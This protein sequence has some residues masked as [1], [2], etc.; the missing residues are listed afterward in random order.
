MWP[1]IGGHG[2]LFK[3]V[4]AASQTCGDTMKA[5]LILL[6]LP[7][8]LLPLACFVYIII[9]ALPALN[10]ELLMGSNTTSG[11]LFA[12]TAGTGHG[13]WGQISGSLLMML[14][15]CFLAAPLALSIA[16]FHALWA[17]PYQ[18]RMMVI[19]LQV[20]QGIP[21]IVYG[22]CG[23][24][25]LVHLLHWGISLA[26]GGVILALVILPLLSSNAIHALERIPIAQTESAKA[27]GL[28]VGAVIV[29]V[30]LPSAWSSMLTG[31]LLAM[32][33]ALSETAPILFTATVF[34]G[35]TWPDSIFS[36][37]TSLQTHIFYLAQEGSN[38]H[39]VDMA[40]A[41]AAVLLGLVLC[42]SLMARLLRRYEGAL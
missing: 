33:R 26:A 12:G 38:A 29:R 30:W 36:P 28:S 13:L 39:A 15:A 40:W 16:L 5:V 32:A 31:L 22:L 37:V 42:F 8:I 1:S 10:W 3:L 4:G 27:L 7:A 35:I 2:H 14:L 34:S 17:S 11:S 9:Q 41:S 25:V 19:L 6:A 21:P 24:I 23:L 20:L 18:Q